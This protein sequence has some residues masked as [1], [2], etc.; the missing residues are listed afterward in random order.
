M[1]NSGNGSHWLCSCSSAN[2]GRAVANAALERGLPRIT[3]Q[4]NL[5]A[6]E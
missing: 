3:Q 2:S 5:K 4:M 6:T 1:N